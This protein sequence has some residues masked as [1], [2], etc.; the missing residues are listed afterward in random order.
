MQK[1]LQN[2]IFSE[3][4]KL[5]LLAGKWQIPYYWNILITS[6]II[7]IQLIF[8]KKEILYYLGIIDCDNR[9]LYKLDFLGIKTKLFQIVNEIQQ[10]ID[11]KKNNKRKTKKRV[12]KKNYGNF[13][14]NSIPVDN[15]KND[16]LPP[17]IPIRLHQSLLK[18]QQ[19]FG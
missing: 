3:L 1:I 5:V 13:Y 12:N 18:T 8:I 2:Y 14:G 16:E 10:L 6:E 15:S 11:E 9:E 17:V 4:Q 19:I 7:F